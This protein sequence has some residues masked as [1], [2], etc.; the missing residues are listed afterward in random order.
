MTVITQPYEK[1]GSLMKNKE[2]LLKTRKELLLEYDGT[3]AA[4]VPD[5]SRLCPGVGDRMLHNEFQPD[6]VYSCTPWY[7]MHMVKHYY[8]RFLTSFNLCIMLCCCFTTY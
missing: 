2:A 5:L 3:D 6:T 1:Q 4:L 7:G 8:F